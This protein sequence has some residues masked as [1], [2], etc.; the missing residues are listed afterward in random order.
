MKEVYINPSYPKYKKLNQTFNSSDI[1]VIE[2][3]L[4]DGAYLQTFLKLPDLELDFSIVSPGETLSVYGYG[5][6][7]RG[8][9][10][11]GIYNKKVIEL[12]GLENTAFSLICKKNFPGLNQFTSII[13]KKKIITA[14]SA[15]SGMSE[16]DSGGPVLRNGKIVGIN[17]SYLNNKDIRFSSVYLNLH[18]RVS[19]V[20]DWI[21]TIIKRK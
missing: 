15:T 17:S 12:A 8:Q 18:T 13:F 10:E 4:I 20:K 3:D 14:A 16:G 7:N 21:L 19:E 1:A 11:Y 9:S 2:I 5:S 6:E